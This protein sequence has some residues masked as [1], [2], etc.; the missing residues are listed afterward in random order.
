M[1]ELTTLARP[2]ARAAFEYA[3]EDSAL[4]TWSLSLRYLAAVV[5]TSRVS[6]IM[7]SPKYAAQ[8]KARALAQI[9]AEVLDAKQQNFIALLA[10]NSRLMLLP[11]ISELFELY[12][13]QE[14]RTVEVDIETAFELSDAQLQELETG[15]RRALSRNV[16]LSTSINHDLLG[17]VLIRAEDTVID[18]SIRGRLNKL[19]GAMTA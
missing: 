9:C 18:A 10:E 7:N 6:K 4:A 2:Y 11:K 14:E 3:R 19:A 8:T 12:K 15:L 13:A 17:G 1:A 16:A 5:A